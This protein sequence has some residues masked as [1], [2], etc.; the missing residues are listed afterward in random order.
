MTNT[1]ELMN[2]TIYPPTTM[3]KGPRELF[4]DD[5]K[6]NRLIGGMFDDVLIGG[7]KND[8]LKGHRGDDYIIGGGGSNKVKGGAGA[9]AFELRMNGRM[10]IKDFDPF[11]G[12]V[13]VLP[14][15][16]DNSDIEWELKRNRW[17]LSID[18]QQIAKFNIPFNPSDLV[19]VVLD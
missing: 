8:T 2:N 1:I 13:V 9:D 3:T 7:S 15:Y 19:T 18:D 16:K 10:V 4:G 17:V 11:E 14:H 6:E 5:N 12:D